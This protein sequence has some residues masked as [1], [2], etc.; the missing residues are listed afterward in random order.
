[1]LF[2]NYVKKGD[3]QYDD[4]ASSIYFAVNK[5]LRE[6]RQHWDDAPCILVGTKRDLR[7]DDYFTGKYRFL[8]PLVGEHVAR[9]TGCLAYVDTSAKTKHGIEDLKRAIV[10]AAQFNTYKQKQKK[11]CS[12]M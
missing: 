12:Q 3:P 7:D 1:M 11:K 5:F 9:E 2:N 6:V 8:P 10:R 4:N